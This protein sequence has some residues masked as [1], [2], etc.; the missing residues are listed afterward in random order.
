MKNQDVDT[1]AYSLGG[2]CYLNIT[3]RCTLRCRFCPKFN[4]EWEIQGYGLRLQHE[5]A[6][7]EVLAALGDP[8][9]YNEVVFCG[10]GEPTLR[11]DVLL[12]VANDV[13]CRGGKVRLNTDGLANM[14]HGRNVLPELSGCIDTVSISMNTHNAWVYEQHCRPQSPASFDAMLAF[15]IDA[16]DYI[17]RVVMTAIDGLPGSSIDLLARDA[18]SLPDGGP[19]IR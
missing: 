3:N 16:V 9:A 10:L 5:P 15:A 11:L 4:G 6:A 13:R 2:N 1:V 19:V 7:G 14:V 8:C 17:P 12:E 18:A